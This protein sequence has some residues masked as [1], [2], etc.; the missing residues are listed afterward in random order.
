MLPSRN[1]IESFDFED[2]TPAVNPIEAEV[3]RSTGY[4]VQKTANNI[5]RV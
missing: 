2:P 4:V 1:E 5:V 3:N